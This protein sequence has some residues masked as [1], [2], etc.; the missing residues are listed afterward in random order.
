[1]FFEK[2]QEKTK[3]LKKLKIFLDRK[4]GE[5]GGKTFEFYNNALN[6]QKKNEIRIAGCCASST[7]RSDHHV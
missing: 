3:S 4:F 1:M 2:R 5:S 7:E 6:K